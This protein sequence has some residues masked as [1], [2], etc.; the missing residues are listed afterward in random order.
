MSEKD[1][2]K[3]VELAKKKLKENRT[4]EEAMAELVSAGIMTKKGN[5]TKPYKNLARI[6]NK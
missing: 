5:F 6:V 3:L 2:K 1:I 4:K